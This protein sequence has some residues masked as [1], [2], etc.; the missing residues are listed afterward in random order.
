ML[1]SC[2]ASFSAE[3]ATIFYL[4]IGAVTFGLARFRRTRRLG[5]KSTIML[6]SQRRSRMALD[7]LDLL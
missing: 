2:L 7:S 1:H 6:F 5:R 4:A 3:P